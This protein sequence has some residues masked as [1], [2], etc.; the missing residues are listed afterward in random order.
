MYFPIYRDP[1]QDK[2]P[3]HGL[4]TKRRFQIQ[5]SRTQAGSST[6]VKSMHTWI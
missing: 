1:E 2:A 4:K 5:D 3:I 6:L